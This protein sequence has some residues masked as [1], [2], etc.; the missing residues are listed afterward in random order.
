MECKGLIFRYSSNLYMSAHRSIEDRR[1]LRLLKR[2]SCSGCD[3]CYWMW[4]HLKEEIYCVESEYL[5]GLI[6]G[7]KYKLIPTGPMDEIE[8]VFKRL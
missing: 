4:E 7:F 6:A 3:N 5:D 8:F 1:S 2:D